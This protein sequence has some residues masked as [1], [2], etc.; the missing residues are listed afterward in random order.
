[1]K[2]TAV[3]VLASLAE[4]SP[5]MS[6]Y[7]LKHLDP[8]L[9]RLTCLLSAPSGGEGAG[10]V[11]C[12]VEGGHADHVCGV[13]CQ[14]LQLHA[15]LG[16]EERPQPLRLVLQLELPEVDLWWWRWW[17]EWAKKGGGAKN[18]VPIKS[19]R[20]YLQ[21]SVA[22]QLNPSVLFSN[23][24]AQSEFSVKTIFEKRK[25]EKIDLPLKFCCARLSQSSSHIVKDRFIRK[26]I[27]HLCLATS[28]ISFPTWKCAIFIDIKISNMK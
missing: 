5:P 12:G 18:R 21:S 13:A 11:P 8:G 25:S 7:G 15:Q 22:L 10:P 24:P 27:F 16:Q 14:V 9:V 6:N 26:F 19:M 1:M 3:T 20:T 17:W 2:P 28:C 23:S 4:K